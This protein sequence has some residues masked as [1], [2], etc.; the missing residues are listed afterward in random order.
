MKSDLKKALKIL[1]VSW[2]V[3]AAENR[4]THDTNQLLQEYLNWTIKKCVMTTYLVFL[5]TSFSV[6]PVSDAWCDM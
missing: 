5:A 6:Q 3:T 2:I 1:G 4:T